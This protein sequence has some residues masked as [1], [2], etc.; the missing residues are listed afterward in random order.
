VRRGARVQ[1]VTV[2]NKLGYFGDLA[3]LFWRWKSCLESGDSELRLSASK[4]NHVWML[5]ILA[6]IVSALAVVTALLI[7]S[8]WNSPDQSQTPPVPAALAPAP[9]PGL[10][11]RVTL[12]DGTPA[13]GATVLVVFPGPNNLRIRDGKVSSDEGGAGRVLRSSADSGGQYQLPLQTGQFTLAAVSQAGYAQFNTN[14]SV[15]SAD[16]QLTPWGRITGRY[17]IGTKPGAHIDLRASSID[18]GAGGSATRIS[19]ASFARTDADGNFTLTGLLPGSTSIERDYLE[20]SAGGRMF[21]SATIGLAQVVEGQTTTII[22][23]GKGR[24]VTGRFIFPSRLTPADILI[25]ARAYSLNSSDESTYFLQTDE[26]HHF[27]ID[28]VPP[29]DYRI[30]IFLQP[31]QG[32]RVPQSSQ[33]RFTVP[34]VTG[35]V[36]DEPLDIGDVHL[37]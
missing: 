30:H 12:A 13:T 2:R 16:L 34:E 3:G 27:R 6:V 8:Q 22:L 31:S 36:S 5:A 23:G 19:I 14:S 20:E 18:S 37:Q 35:G 10:H 24:P 33:P 1:K 25:N 32:P 11:G 26:H 28:N 29:G 21:Y 15:S 17:M 4:P 9:T 7:W